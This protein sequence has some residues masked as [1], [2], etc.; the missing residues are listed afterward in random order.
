[1]AKEIDKYLMS[2]PK[3]D[4]LKPISASE[5]T[6]ATD[7]MRHS[8]ISAL[9]KKSFYADKTTGISHTHVPK[10]T[11]GKIQFLKNNTTKTMC[12]RLVYLLEGRLRD[13]KRDIPMIKNLFLLAEFS[14]KQ[15]QDYVMD[16]LR[17]EGKMLNWEEIVKKLLDHTF[18]Y[19]NSD[20]V[21]EFYNHAMALGK[22]YGSKS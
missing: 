10:V 17:R 7:I 22:K 5:Y 4:D 21:L 3:G 1:M 9:E 12:K 14:Y 6:V 8:V 18:D 15:G 11:I 19:E 20:L 2:I 16:Y 13:Y